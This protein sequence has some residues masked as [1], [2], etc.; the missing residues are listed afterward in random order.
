MERQLTAVF[1]SDILIDFLQGHEAARDAIRQV[2]L[3]RASIITWMEVMVGA[4]RVGGET[5][6]DQLFQ[7]VPVVPLD[8][9]IASRAIDLRISQRLKLPDAIV[10]AT[11]RELSAIL[12]TRNTKD[13][14]VDERDILVPYHV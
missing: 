6:A 2:E 11:A 12:V 5:A 10:L 7:A 8:E 3:P 9:A 13:F 4:R 1:D 14:P